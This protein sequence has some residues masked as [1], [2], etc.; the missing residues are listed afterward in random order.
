MP[1]ET[2]EKIINAAINLMSL[3]GYS[4]TTTKEIAQFAGLS[5]MTLFRKFKNKQEI[6]DAVI[7]TYT[8]AFHSEKLFTN[9]EVTYDLETDLANVSR[10]YQNFMSEN[11]KVVLLAYKESGTHD[12]ISETLT[13]NPR[14]MKKFLVDYLTEMEKRGKIIDTNIEVVVFSFMTMNLGYF[15]AQFISGK[16]VASVPLDAFIEHSVKVFARGLKKE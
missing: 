14:L 8:C 10:T 11:K 6:L 5:E 1:Q 9:N 7:K 15:S 12:E 4:S 2:R 3:K 13:V 16:K